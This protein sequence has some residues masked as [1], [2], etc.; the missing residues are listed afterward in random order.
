MRGFILLAVMFCSIVKVTALEIP[1]SDELQDEFQKLEKQIGPDGMKALSALAERISAYRPPARSSK[2]ETPQHKIIL[3][4]MTGRPF[5]GSICVGCPKI[6]PLV[7]EVNDILKHMPENRDACDPGS[8]SPEIQK[9]EALYYVVVFETQAVCKA[10]DDFVSEH[11]ATGYVEL[12]SDEMPLEQ[13]DIAYLF[14]ADGKRVYFYKAMLDGEK[15]FIRI[16]VL[17][18]KK[19]KVSIYKLIPAKKDSTPPGSS[20]DPATSA[21]RGK[22]WFLDNAS[23]SHEATGQNNQLPQNHIKITGPDISDLSNIK[24]VTANAQYIIPKTG[25]AVLDFQGGVTGKKSNVRIT[26][27]TDGQHLLIITS[28]DKKPLYVEVPINF[29]KSSGVNASAIYEMSDT[30]LEAKLNIAIPRH[31]ETFSLF[32][33]DENSDNLRYGM[34]VSKKIGKKKNV[35]LTGTASVSPIGVTYIGVGCTIYLGSKKK[36]VSRSEGVIQN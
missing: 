32:F 17:D 11:G 13:L 36:A 23:Y 28:S 10:M 29:L 27:S 25:G 2:L 5:G 21:D 26:I 12:T 9:F 33:V 35:A 16:D 3:E 1:G 24:V 4:P 15:V 20:Q 30:E 6:L 18:D 31:S 22:T 8:A 19:A 7:G 14:S 34:T